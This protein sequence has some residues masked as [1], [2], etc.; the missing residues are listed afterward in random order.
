MLLSELQD[1]QKTKLLLNL[2]TLQSLLGNK[3]L[4]KIIG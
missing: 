2:F 1:C 4:A 3:K